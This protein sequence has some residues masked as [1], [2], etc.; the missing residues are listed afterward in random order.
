MS[1][2]ETSLIPTETVACGEQTLTVRGLG[3]ADIAHIMR[4]HSSV[5]AELY[6]QAIAGTLPG[7]VEEIA[8]TMVGDFAPLAGLVIACSVDEPHNAAIAAKL[9]LSVQAEAL[10]KIMLLTLIAAGGLEKLMEIVA[11][12]M[13]SAAK[14]TSLKT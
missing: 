5:L 14:L 12:A 4:F 2:L 9:P 8:L 6:T 10:E 13:A 11:K 3:L 7:S 1:Q